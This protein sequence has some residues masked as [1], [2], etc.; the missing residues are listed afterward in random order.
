MAGKKERYSGVEHGVEDLVEKSK[1]DIVVRRQAAAL[2]LMYM[3][4]LLVLSTLSCEA[5]KASDSPHAPGTVVPLA[6]VG[7]CGAAEASWHVYVFT[8]HAW[9]VC[10][11]DCLRCRVA[12]LC[13]LAPMVS[14][15]CGSSR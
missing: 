10:A 6:A 5:A 8:F 3:V 11:T 9:H 7:I 15:L 4:V 14:R 2:A 1:V 13:F 12:S